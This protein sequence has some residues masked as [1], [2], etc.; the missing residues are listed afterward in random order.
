MPEP[1]RVR[2]DATGHEYSTY[3]RSEGETVLD[4]PAVDER[5]D[6]LPAKPA[7]NRPAEAPVDTNPDLTVTTEEH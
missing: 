2:D 3:S 1:Q 5:G 6:L 4:E 7:L